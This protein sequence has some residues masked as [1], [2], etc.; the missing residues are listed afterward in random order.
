MADVDL[1]AWI[2]RSEDTL[3]VAE[4][5]PLERLAALLIMRR[6]PWRA[7][8]APPLAHWLYFLPHARQSEIAK[9]GHPFKGGFLPPTPLPRRMFGGSRLTFHAP[10]A[11]GAAIERHSPPSPGSARQ[12]RVQRRDDRRHRAQRVLLRTAR[13]PCGQRGAGRHLPRGGQATAKPQPSSAGFAAPTPAQWSRLQP[14]RRSSVQLFRYSALTFNGHRI[15]YDRPYARERG[16]LPGPGGARPVSPPPCWWI[17]TRAAAR[18]RRSRGSRS[19][20]GGH[21]STPRRSRSC[22]VE[23]EGRGSRALDGRTRRRADHDGQP[24]GGMTYDLLSG[25][26][27]VDGA[28]FAIAAPSCG[29]HLLQMWAAPR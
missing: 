18:A 28:S 22:G 2:G 16:R 21:C 1:Q 13:C 9:D 14:H 24:D 10:L 5:G 15:H 7:G 19:A 3:D 20:R 25:L 4:P 12:D 11:I 17:T 23:R 8:E 6:S 26:R 29:L 27:V